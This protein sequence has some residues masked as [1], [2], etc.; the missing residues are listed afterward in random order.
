M[1]IRTAAV[2][3]SLETEWGL[4]KVEVT[5]HVGGMNSH[6][7]FI[8]SGP[9]R[10][11][12][13]AVP[14][15]AHRRFVSG[16]AVASLVRAAGIPSGS[17]VPARDGRPFVEIAGHTLALL[18]FVRGSELRGEDGREQRLIG[19]TLARAHGALIGQGLADADR[20]H[21]IDPDAAHLQIRDWLR[22][23]ITEVLASWEGLPPAS[24]TWGLLH[25]D[26]APEAF[27]LDADTGVCGLIDWDTGIVGPLMYDLASAVMYVGGPD[28]AMVLI[29]AYLGQRVLDRSEISRTLEP[30]LRMRWAVQADY[31][32][33]R[34][35][36]NDMTGIA[37][38]QENEQGLDD[39][40]RLHLAPGPVD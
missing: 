5:P 14:G 29:D 23:A 16:L 31:F 17:S 20:F 7:W 9:D 39:A 10:Y 35:S 38:P 8:R 12:A 30:M 40:A 34:L 18:T 26:P 15:A 2:R 11:V 32:A 37:D 22:P 19:S 6:T 4:R 3:R 1:T 21:W 33:R 25:T 24:L 36:T 27:L 28:H 13:K